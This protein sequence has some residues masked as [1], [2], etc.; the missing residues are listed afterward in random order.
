V[1]HEDVVPLARP[2]KRSVSDWAQQNLWRTPLHAAISLAVLLLVGYV[3]WQFLDWA[4]VSATWAGVTREACTD[5]GACWP[6]IRARFNQLMYGFY[7]REEQWRVNVVALVLLACFVWFR[8][9]AAPRKG[10]LAVAVVLAV[11]VLVMVLIHGGYGLPEVPTS[12]W[13][14]LMLTLTIAFAA[15]AA[16]LPLGILLA[17]ARRSKMPAVSVI[18]VGFIELVRAVPLISV[19]FMAS[20]LLP[21][22]LPQEV[23]FDKLARALIGVALFASAYMAEVVRGGLQA[24]P[25]GQAEAA[26]SL[27][28]SNARL[29]VLVV[30]PQALRI[31]I[32]GIANTFIAIFKDTSLVIIIGL[33]DLLGMIN[34]SVND[35]RWIGMEM[36]GFVFAAAIYWVFCSAI[37][38]YTRGLE[39]RLRARQ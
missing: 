28:L 11:P 8:V 7:P 20:V 13:G 27:G 33:F 34:A 22:F 12:K 37:S 9:P 18:A 31:A 25:A 23:T 17:L 26:R 3:L 30:L 14:G 6:F 16:S 4:V 35:T 32:P 38:R 5:E 19:L 29:M 39:D 15:I 24:V 10:V 21:I 2:K 1:T 36:E